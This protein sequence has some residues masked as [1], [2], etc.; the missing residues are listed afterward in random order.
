[1]GM[2]WGWLK[3]GWNVVRIYVKM[4]L[5]NMMLK[6]VEMMLNGTSQS[7][8]VAWCRGISHVMF[9]LRAIIWSW[10]LG[11]LGRL[12]VLNHKKDHPN[13]ECPMFLCCCLGCSTTTT[14]TKR[15]SLPMTSHDV[16]CR[17]SPDPTSHASAQCRYM[18][19]DVALKC[20]NKRYLCICPSSHVHLYC[21]LGALKRPLNH[22]YWTICQD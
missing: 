10:S 3:W 6:Y 4:M 11:R 19:P 9:S 17:L 16:S 21:F 2:V 15:S 5:Y 20:Y 1:M 14:T 13:P 8:R 12:Q 22:V 7:H 18:W